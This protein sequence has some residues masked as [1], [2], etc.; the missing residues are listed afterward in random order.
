MLTGIFAKNGLTHGDRVLLQ[1]MSASFLMNTLSYANPKIADSVILDGRYLLA[2]V[3]SGQF[4]FNTIK[5]AMW[6]TPEIYAAKEHERHSLMEQESAATES[7]RAQ[8][9]ASQRS[10]DVSR[11]S[12]GVSLS[13]GP[14]GRSQRVIGRNP[15]KLYQSAGGPVQSMFVS[16]DYQNFSGGGQGNIA[17]RPQR[18][19]VADDSDITVEMNPDTFGNQDL[20]Y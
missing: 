3:M 11:P 7:V 15:R 4:G 1:N 20:D 18:S 14:F 16:G 8:Q 10:Y 19:S 17:R 13:Q 12:G 5:N 2:Q 6:E 9:E